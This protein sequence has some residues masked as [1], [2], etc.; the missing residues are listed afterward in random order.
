LAPAI[1]VVVTSYNSRPHI[2]VALDSLRAQEIDDPYEVIVVDSGEDGCA[3]RV[4]EEYPEVRVVRSP[5]RLYPGAACN[6]GIEAAKGDLIGFLPSDCA[7]ERSWLRRRLAKHREGFAAVGGAVTNGT[8]GHPIGS[9]GYYLEYTGVLPSERIL[10]E[11]NV[12]HSLSYERELLE[13]LDGFPEDMVAG[14]DTVLNKRCLAEGVSIAVDP[15]IQIAHQNLRS[16]WP[17]LR[18]QW[19]HGRARVYCAEHYGLGSPTHPT[20][21]PLSVIFVTVLVTSP[22]RRFFRA[23]RRVARGE[24]RLLPAY[25]ALGPLQLAGAW[26]AALGMWTELLRVRRRSRYPRV[27]GSGGGG[28]RT[29]EGPEGP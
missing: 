25:I 19:E 24:P 23:L 18:H 29:H 9:A 11:Q 7:A 27:A 17:Y 13:R 10:A 15:R 5:R 14:E 21:R 2:D 22:V 16:L 8:P 26:S 20:N 4:Q 3:D 6:L 12:P 28:I 1:S